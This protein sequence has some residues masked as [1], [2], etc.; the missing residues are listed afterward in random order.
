MRTFIMVLLGSCLGSFYYLAIIRS[1]RGEEFIISRSH[2][3]YCQRELSWWEMIPVL[4]YLLLKGKCRKC[5]QPINKGHLYAEA[6]GLMISLLTGDNTRL[7]ILFN[8]I[9]IIDIYDALYQEIPLQW[10][11]ILALYCLTCGFDIN[12]V[13][14]LVVPLSV[15]CLLA[16]GMG[17]GDIILLGCLANVFGLAHSLRAIIISCGVTGLYMLVKKQGKT[18]FCPFLTAGFLI[19]IKLFKEVFDLLPPFM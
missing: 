17:A 3:E 11:L 14:L 1:E 19:E 2:C 8:I 18:A 16:K 7:F 10:F 12:S 9:F 13:L 15:L 4:S 6:A 5:Q